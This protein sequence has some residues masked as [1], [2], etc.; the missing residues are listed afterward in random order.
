MLNIIYIIYYMYKM[1]VYIN[2]IIFL[3]LKQFKGT[4]CTL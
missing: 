2:T 4:K 3:V 1:C